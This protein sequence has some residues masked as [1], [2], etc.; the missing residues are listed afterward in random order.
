MALATLEILD[1]IDV[2]DQETWP[3][4]KSLAQAYY[5]LAFDNPEH[6]KSDFWMREYEYHWQLHLD[7]QDK[8]IPF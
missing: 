8:Y 2:W 4:N 5:D 3:D 6:E 1:S 7:G